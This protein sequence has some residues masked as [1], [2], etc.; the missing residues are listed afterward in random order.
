MKKIKLTTLINLLL[1]LV[2]TSK[3]QVKQNIIFSD[4][5]VLQRGVSVPVWG[6]AKDGETVTVAFAGQKQNAV[7]KNGKWMVKLNPLKEGGPFTMTIT[8]SNTITIKNILVG[9]VWIC[10]GQSNM[11]RQLGPRNGQ[12]LIDNWIEEAADGINYPNMREFSVQHIASDTPLAEVKAKWIVCDSVTSKNFSAV[13]YFFGRELYKKLKVPIGLIHTSWGGTP[14]EK[15]TSREMLEAAPELKVLV[16]VYDKAIKNYP[17]TLKK[18]RANESD[19]LAKWAADTLIAKQNNKPLP[20]K[21]A[22]PVNL[23]KSGDCGGLYNAMIAP[24]I[25]YAFKGV[26]WYQGESNSS[27]AKQYQTLFPTMI[28]DWRN[29]WQQGNFPFLFVQIAPNN[30]NSPELREAQLLT[31]QN[32]PNTAMAVITDC[33]DTT[34]NLHPAQKKPVGERLAL[35][36]RALAYGEKIEYSG[37]IYQSMKIDGN[38][39]ILNFTHVGKGLVAKDGDLK[40]FTIADSNKKFVPA[41]AEIKGNSVVVFADSVP[42]PITVRFGFINKPIANFYN[43]EGLPASPFRTDIQ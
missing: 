12:P 1:L 42:N 18:Y 6:I 43:K 14:A 23:A 20:R 29:K 3:A 33:V 39:I 34:F 4:N 7:A 30:G 13:G 19:L 25:P 5:M 8:A 24:L 10:S 31:M 35:A 15:W 17:D 38:K 22:P 16:D 36:A 21:P 26:I 9:E 41:K 2:F 32:T 27:R 11:E 37:P 40:G 28:T